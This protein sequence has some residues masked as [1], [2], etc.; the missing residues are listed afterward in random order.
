MDFIPEIPYIYQPYEIFLMLEINIS[1]PDVLY[2][3]QLFDR[4]G[5]PVWLNVLK[6]TRFFCFRL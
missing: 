1:V 3:Y 2:T 4:K 6:S 5:L